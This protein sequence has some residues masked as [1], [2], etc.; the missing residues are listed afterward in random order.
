MKRNLAVPM[1]RCRLD[2]SPS[3]SELRYVPAAEFD[4]W[5][6]LMA[7]KYVRGVEV[8]EVSVWVP[9]MAEV[10]DE[11]IAVDQLHEVVRVRFDKPGPQGTMVPVTRFFP[12]ETYPE[13]K[14]ALLAHFDL[15]CRWGVEVTPGYFVSTAASRSVDEES[16]GTDARPSGLERDLVF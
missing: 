7:N 13:A 5:R 10:F 1:V 15:R 8:D 2:G 14:A 11:G 16:L 3:S 6:H 12:A 4:L 9:D